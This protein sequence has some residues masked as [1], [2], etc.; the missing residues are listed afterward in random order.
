M[1]TDYIDRQA[2]IAYI[3][4]QKWRRFEGMTIEDAIITMISEVPSAVVPV[5]HGKW[6]T[7]VR[8]IDGRKYVGG[9]CSECGRWLNMDTYKYCPNCGTRMDGEMIDGTGTETGTETVKR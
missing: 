1:M 8:T 4:L 3:K 2:A 6:D 5:K 9:V 7:L